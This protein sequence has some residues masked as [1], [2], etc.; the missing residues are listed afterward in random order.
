V[1]V[2]SVAASAVDP[3]DDLWGAS[4]G[5]SS[6]PRNE[7]EFGDLDVCKRVGFKCDEEESSQI[8]AGLSPYRRSKIISDGI[9][10]CVFI[11]CTC[12]LLIFGGC[13]I[14][15]LKSFI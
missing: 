14:D 3:N 10:V 8:E 5:E 4:K 11:I 9:D 15:C 1:K 7:R 13:G 12:L 2:E 6:E